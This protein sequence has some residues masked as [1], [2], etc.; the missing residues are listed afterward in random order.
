MS[1]IT[2]AHLRIRS[3]TA[4]ARVRRNRPEELR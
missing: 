1:M 3:E 2:A 4:T